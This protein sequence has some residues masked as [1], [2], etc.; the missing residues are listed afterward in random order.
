M[1]L[2]EALLKRIEEVGFKNPTPIQ[3]EAI[4]AAIQ[5]RD[6]IAGAKTGSGK[7]A[8]FCLPIIQG[9]EG[10]RGTYAV[11][12]SPTREIALQTLE[13]IKLL[14]EPLG[15][16]SCALIGGTDLK[17]DE[18]AL[19]SVPHVIVGTPGRVCDHILRGNLWLEFIEVLVLD[20]ADKMLD[21]GFAKELNQIVSQTKPSRQT[22]LFSA[23]I[24]PTIEQLANKILRN[25]T[26]IQIGSTGVTVSENVSHEI[27]WVNDRSKK[28]EL[29]RAL[30]EFKGTVIIF[31]RTKD[32]AS[33]LWRSIHAAG[34]EDSTYISSN[35]LQVHREA[36]LKGFK[37]GE[38]RVLVATD[39]AGRGIHVDDVGMVINYDLPMEPED[40]VHRIGRTGRKEAKG[41]AVSFCTASDLRQIEAIERLIRKPIPERFS[42]DFEPPA[43]GR[44]H[45]ARGSEARGKTSSSREGARRSSHRSGEQRSASRS[46]ASESR[47]ESRG[48]SAEPRSASRRH[49]AEENRRPAR[50]HAEETPRSARRH[51]PEEGSRS[52]RR[53]SSEEGLRPA[54]RHGADES[55]RTARRNHGEEGARPRRHAARDEA[56]HSRRHTSDEDHRSP[57]RPISEEG[58]RPARRSVAETEHHSS[59]RRSPEPSEGRHERTSHSR[60]RTERTERTERSERPRASSRHRDDDYGREPR[61]RPRSSARDSAERSPR[62]SSRDTYAE[63]SERSHPRE[64]ADETDESG[65]PRKTFRSRSST[66]GRSGGR[67]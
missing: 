39:V 30:R 42:R 67:R 62:H 37:E 55:H 38:Y 20:E 54:R 59:H 64:S 53:Q 58:R 17:A 41:Y 49:G 26:R 60:G 56:R 61:P 11:I 22:L 7:T 28:R 51:G 25:P 16:T 3:A 8:A 36:A 33:L 43:Q 19:R 14:G 66:Y 24:P 50:R 5:G 47:H 9:L 46:R 27:L 44:G 32:G 65:L 2:S 12:L 45:T 13:T 29:L 6:L 18:A 40:Y 31:T 4:P 23:T 15:I 21:M 34:I 63:P 10:R 35:K 48:R 57:R 1:G 52:S